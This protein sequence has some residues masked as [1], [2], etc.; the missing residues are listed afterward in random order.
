M[1]TYILI[2]VFMLSNGNVHVAHEGVRTATRLSKEQCTN[3]LER[4]LEEAKHTP[5]LL[6]VSGGCKEVPPAP[7]TGKEIGEN[8]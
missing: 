1:S 6:W 4:R 2:L 7:M 3:I 8:T 5:E